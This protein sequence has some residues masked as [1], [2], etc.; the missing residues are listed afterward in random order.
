MSSINAGTGVTY[1]NDATT[2]LDLQG[3][4]V[5]AISVNTQAPYVKSVTTSGRD[6]LTG[7]AGM[8]VYNSTTDTLNGFTG[9]FWEAISL[10]IPAVPT[11]RAIFG[12][13]TSG[14]GPVSVTNLVSNTGVV[15]TDV[16]GVGTARLGIAAA[17]YGL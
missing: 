16:T 12:Y 11:Q 14:S 5:T 9:T 2:V 7:V 10:I 1:N 17:G 15:G 3:G 13:G 8:M 4:G 6:G